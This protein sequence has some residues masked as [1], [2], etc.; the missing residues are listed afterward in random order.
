MKRIFI[1]NGHP[2]EQSL[3]RTLVEA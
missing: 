2:A 3:S 1:L